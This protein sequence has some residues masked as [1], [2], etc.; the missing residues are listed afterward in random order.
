MKDIYKYIEI[1]DE[2]MDTIKDYQ[3]KKQDNQI[4]TISII[5]NNGNIIVDIGLEDLNNQFKDI[6]T[7]VL[8]LDF[9]KYILPRIA[10][11]YNN[12]YQKN[13]EKLIKNDNGTANYINQST[14]GD[15]FRLINYSI[16]MVNYIKCLID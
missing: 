11:K 5:N 7:K 10:I 9:D 2:I 15:T 16:D 14:V 6:R 8:D 13:S 1:Y 4:M 12:W 3:N